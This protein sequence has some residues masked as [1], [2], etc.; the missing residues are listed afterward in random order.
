MKQ[1]RKIAPVA[2]PGGMA[3][4]FVRGFVTC[5]AVAMLERRACGKGLAVDVEVVRYATLGGVALMAGVIAGNAVQRR[6]YSTALVGVVAG[7]GGVYALDRLMCGKAKRK[8]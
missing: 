4:D 8:E 5:G 2:T 3:N 1:R 7:L 6:D